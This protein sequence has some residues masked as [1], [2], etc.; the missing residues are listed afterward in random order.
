MHEQLWEKLAALD[1]IETS[2]RSRCS[3]D[4]DSSTFIVPLM[5]EDFVVDC[6]QRLI[7][8]ADDPETAAGFLEQLCI[9]SHL[10]NASDIPISGK[11]VS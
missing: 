4:T 1:P 5:G 9:L 7:A 10:I 6:G 11:L 3:F 8:P 2:R